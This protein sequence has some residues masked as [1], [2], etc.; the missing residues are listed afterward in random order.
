MTPSYLNMGRM[1]GVCKLILSAILKSACSL[2]PPVVG[3]LSISLQYTFITLSGYNDGV[4]KYSPSAA[5][6]FAVLIDE[7]LV[8][9]TTPVKNE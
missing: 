3:A 2:L 1:S 4:I 8:K 5:L 6:G 9:A 7:Q